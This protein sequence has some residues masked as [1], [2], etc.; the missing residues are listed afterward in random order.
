MF[1]ALSTFTIANDM[2]PAVKQ[3]FI[4]RPG[5]VEG[6]PGFIRLQV[7]SPQDNPQEIWLITHWQDEESYKTWHHSHMYHDSHSG[8][9]KGLKLVPRSAKVRF[10]EHICE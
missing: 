2:A 1:I 7:I 10:F 6:A 4:N 9:P 3:A 8:I 5:L